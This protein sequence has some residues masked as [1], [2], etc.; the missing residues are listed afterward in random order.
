MSN[1][2]SRVDRLFLLGLRSP[3][4][5]HLYRW[6]LVYRSKIHFA[7]TGEGENPNTLTRPL[8]SEVTR[9]V[10]AERVQFMTISNVCLFGHSAFPSYTFTEYCPFVLNIKSQTTITSTHRILYVE[11]CIRRTLD[12]HRLLKIVIYFVLK[13]LHNIEYLC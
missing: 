5:A 10:A 11:R 4:N 9:R 7:L 1:G 13:N 3:T 2:A 12:R 8:T 6:I